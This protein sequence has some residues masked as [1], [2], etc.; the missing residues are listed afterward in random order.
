MDS[1][2]ELSVVIAGGGFCGILCLV[3]FVKKSTQKI[4]VSVINGKYPL[5]C[6]IAFRTYSNQHLLNVEA[7]NMSAFPDEPDHFVEWCRKNPMIGTHDADVPTTYFPRNYYGDYLGQ[8]LKETLQ[9]AP[10]HI[11]INLITDEVTDVN[12]LQDKYEVITAGGMKISA[13]KIILATGNSEPGPPSL[14]EP[15]FLGSKN[16]FSNPWSE[17]SVSGLTKNDDVLIIG[18]GLTMV[19]VILGLREKKFT[20]KIISLSPHGFNILPHRKAPPQRYILD[21]LSPPYDLETLFRLFYKHIREARTRGQSGE[22]VVDAIRAKTQEIWTNLSVRDKKKFMTHLRH[23]WGV[24]RHRLPA[25]VHQQIQD[26]IKENKLDV[27]AARVKH[28]RECPEGIEV[29]AQRRRDQSELRLRVARVINC[30]G[31]ETDIRKQKSKLFDSLLAKGIVRPD[32]MNLG[33]DAN[34]T[35]NVIGTDNNPN[36][37]IYA[38]GSLLKGKLWESTAVPEL[39]IQ[40]E[41]IV[42]HILG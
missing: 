1:K 3:H 18:N 36:E 31:P 42:Q 38:I 37:S 9:S 21:E 7:R 14:K 15:E 34:D 19:D 11:N 6:G 2:N 35:F 8:I 23:L 22:T 20:G 24:A 4:S 41:K 29:L 10:P 40:A 27:I 5:A 26:M 13:D 12:T 32:D 17:E 16:Y 39:R 30:T 28:I 33:I 25:L